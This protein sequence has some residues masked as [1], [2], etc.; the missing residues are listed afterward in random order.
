MKTSRKE[1]SGALPSV[2]TLFARARSGERPAFDALFALA[3]DRVLYF[4]HLRLGSALKQQ[5]ESVDILQD[6]YLDAYTSFE[7]FAASDDRAFVRWLCRVA[8]N[9]IR[10]CRDYIEAK[11][12]TPPG[13][14]HPI[15][16]VLQVARD[17]GTGPVTAAERADMRERLA[18]AM[19]ELAEEERDV[20]AKRHFE[21]M[22]IEEIGHAM[23]RSETAV[24]R[25]LGRAT[26]KLGRTLAPA[27]GGGNAAHG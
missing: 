20:L 21:D 19:R 13:G 6:T 16:K 26:A 11:K 1:N 4:I 24:R 23:G 17:S 9:R 14:V 27:E 5:V 10:D 22:T 2:A 3:A 25:L 7:T 8:E 18:K 12:R 15:S